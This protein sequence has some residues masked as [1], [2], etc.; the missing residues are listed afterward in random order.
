MT[1]A[2][3][4]PPTKERPG[5]F[6]AFSRQRRA[7]DFGVLVGAAIALMVV[8]VLLGAMSIWAALIAGVALAAFAAVFFSAAAS[9]ERDAMRTASEAA[10][11][12][13]R[14]LRIDSERSFRSAMVDALTEPALY[15][16]AQGKV[17]AANAAA[18]KRFRFLGVGPLLTVAVRRPELIDAVQ[19]ARNGGGPQF[20]DFV[21]R[22]ETDRHFSGVAT[23]LMTPTSTG[24]LVSMHD[25][26]EIKRAEFARVDFLANASHELRTPLTSLSGFIETLRG[27]ARD[28]PA[29]RERFLEIMQGQAERMRRLIQDLLSL[30]RIELSEHRTPDTEADLAAVVAEAGD[31]LQPVAA[32]RQVS[33]RISGPASGV[34]VTGVRDELAQVAQNLIDNAI[35]YS[36]AG[37]VVEIE[38][39][40][41]LSQEEA[42]RQAGR[43]WVEAGHMSIATAPRSSPTAVSGRYAVLRVSDSGP[44]IDRQYLPRLA[45]RFYRVDPGRGLRQGTGLGLA[46]VKH[47][48]A[49]HRGE[50]LVESEPGK[51]SAFGVVLPS[52]D[53]TALPA[54]DAANP[55]DAAAGRAV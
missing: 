17:E 35:K 50:F 20:F 31:A 23:P 51:G 38:I 54:P 24:V 14:R 5:L 16:D 34:L 15:I 29:A 46:I 10:A 26:T 28:D 21:E 22:D 48:I 39:L 2:A 4:P 11:G 53:P 9:L 36:E 42:A 33:L 44:G 40:T 7:S 30:S 3:T 55:A 19:A 49:R 43:R 27:P 41:G 1:D 6:Q 32:E 25:L 37:D 45:E 13:A 52:R 18:R 47:V 8:C 12:E